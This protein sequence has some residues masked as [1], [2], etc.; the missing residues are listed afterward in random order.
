M[1]NVYD[2]NANKLIEKTAEELKKLVKAPEYT[3]Y[4]KTGAGN[5]RPPADKE[6][7]YKRL[8]GVL[9]SVYLKGPLGVNRLRTKYG[10]KRNIGM[11]GKSVRKASGKILRNCLQQLEQ[12]EFIKKGQKGLHKGRII[13]D[14]GKSFLDKLAK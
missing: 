14:K 5:E 7:Y 10:S 3:M 4:V 13:T 2:I 12:L 8:A 11:D 1:A 9:R 6:W